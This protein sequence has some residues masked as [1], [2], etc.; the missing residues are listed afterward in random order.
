MDRS[1]APDGEGDDMPITYSFDRELGLVH[2]RCT[3]AVTLDEVVAHF[4]S[5]ES[6]PLLPSCP[7][8]L[9]DLAGTES[10]P[11]SRQLRSVVDELQ[12]MAPRVVFGACAI[13]ATSDALF[14]MSRM[15]EVFAERQFSRTHVFRD[16][17]RARS[18]LIQGG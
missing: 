6:D 4:R 2:T 3:G 15:F 17:S 10:V 13:V 16:L 8:V 7:N 12:R 5:L 14:G 18:W 11:E 9:L 1:D